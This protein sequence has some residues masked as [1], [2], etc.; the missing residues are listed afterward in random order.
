MI[1]TQSTRPNCIALRVSKKG[2]CPAGVGVLVPQ[3][4][5]SDTKL[6]L[7][8]KLL[9]CRS[10]IKIATF[11]VKTL[12]RICQLP[13]QAASAI[14]HNIDIRCIHEHRYLHS[15]NMKY[16]YTGNGWTFVSAS[17]WKNSVNGAIG[18]VGMLIGPR[19]LK[20]LNREH[21]TEDDGSY[22]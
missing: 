15:E 6:R 14:D 21:T 9:K 8:Q 19:A 13:E 7:K 10:S 2:A 3:F 4:E 18:G 22:V 12:N 20:S 16:H 11:K 5:R 17:T 1:H